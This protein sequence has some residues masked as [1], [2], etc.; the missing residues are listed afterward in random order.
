MRKWFGL[1]IC[2]FLW[3][4]VAGCRE[5]TPPTPTTA[6]VVTAVT[7]ATAT[8]TTPT[9]WITLQP[10]VN[11]RLADNFQVTDEQQGVCWLGSLAVDRPDAWRCAYQDGDITPILDPCFA[12]RENLGEL[13]CLNS[14]LSVTL[15]TLLKPLPEEFANVTGI[16]RLPLKVTLANGD[17]CGLLLGATIT[18]P[19]DG[20]E[21][22]V[23]YGCE[24]GGVLIGLPQQQGGVWTITYNA[25]PRGAA[26]M[27]TVTISQAVV[28]NGTTATLGGAP[29]GE[30]TARITTILSEALP[31]GHRFTIQFDGDDQ[32]GFE[33][34]Y[35][36]EPYVTE[37]MGPKV[38][39]LAFSYPTEPDADYTGERVVT[40]DFPAHVNEVKLVVDDGRDLIWAL[41]LDEMV[42]YDVNRSGDQFI[43]TLFD[44]V[45]NATE[46]PDLGVGSQGT[47]VR[48]V[49]EKLHHLG[50]LTEIPPGE[51]YDEPTRQAVVAF[52][53][54]RGIIPNGVVA[55]ETW[56][57]LERDALEPEGSSML[58]RYA[59]K[60]ATTNAALQETPQV[61]PTGSAGAN[62]RNG[63]GMNYAVIAVLAFGQMAE[64][65][66]LIEGSSPETT[67]VQVCCVAGIAGWVRG[68]VVQVAG[69]TATLPPASPDQPA[70]VPPDLTGVTMPSTRPSSTASGQPILYFTFDDGPSNFTGQ[71]TQA[72]QPFGGLGT[73]FVIGQNVT[74]LPTIAQ[75]TFDAGHAVE[76]HTYSHP[77]LDTLT[78]TQFFDEI[79]RTQVA[80]QNATGY[81]PFCLRPPYGATNDQTFQLAAEMG[82]EIV[83]WSIDTQDWRRPG[84]DAIANHILES[85]F[86][87]AIILMHDGG[88][89]RSQSVAALQQVLPLLQQQGYVFNVLCR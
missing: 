48:A 5:Q 73:F 63:P 4:L 25:D 87:G 84:V 28:F 6:A 81:T 27:E 70:P 57:A 15:L 23:N 7:E 78:P 12:N 16:D 74:A 26:A 32:P 42:G 82:L 62:V 60:A 50:Y 34:G 22:R 43:V 9:E 68:D 75:A 38:L 2:V 69:S 54:D 88:G 3:L 36:N 44:P 65:I 56:A 52:Q 64:A 19:V 67:W 1:V 71:M 47:A 8:P 66:G 13:A 18:V 46:R 61:T 29:I 39:G 83:L 79:E 14:D 21:Q 31:G 33:M 49:Q 40:G 11:G 30:G 45:P 53:I 35:V 86:P 41:G 17:S 77:S 89:D 76:N 72:L 20:D 24:S 59:A 51:K 10:W 80:I 58:H 37:V 85:A 55:A